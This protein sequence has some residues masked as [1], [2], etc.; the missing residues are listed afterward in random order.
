MTRS[1]RNYDWGQTGKLIKHQ[2]MLSYQILAQQSPLRAK[3]GNYSK[4]ILVNFF[5]RLPQCYTSGGAFFR[6]SETFSVAMWGM[7]VSKQSSVMQT[8]GRKWTVGMVGTN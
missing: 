4:P 7:L 2:T 3:P 8:C 5:T 6:R 1:G